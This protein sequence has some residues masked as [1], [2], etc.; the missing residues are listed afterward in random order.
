MNKYDRFCKDFKEFCLNIN[1]TTPELFLGETED[2]I[3]S[4][5]KKH[6]IKLPEGYRSILKHTGKSLL[7]YNSISL[8]INNTI[9]NIEHAINCNNDSQFLKNI[10]LINSNLNNILPIDYYLE[11]SVMSFISLDDDNPHTYSYYGD[12]GDLDEDDLIINPTWINSLRNTIFSELVNKFKDDSYIKTSNFNPENIIDNQY[13][14]RLHL[15]IDDVKWASIYINAYKN[16]LD[17]NWDWY[18]DEFEEMASKIE[19]KENRILGVDEFEWMY[20]D[21]LKEKGEL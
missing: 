17:V 12:N 18:R 11:S 14:R 2:N 1:I 3:S 8:E 7:F 9:S 10:P 4:F 19:V 21:Y 16:G 6:F 20:I 5:E 13:K 15:R